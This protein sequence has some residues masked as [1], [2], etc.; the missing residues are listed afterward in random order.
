MVGRGFR[1]CENKKDCLVLD[2]GNNILRHGPVDAIYVR[3]QSDKSDKKM[4]QGKKCPDCNTVVALATRTCPDCGFQFPFETAR[5]EGNSSGNAPLTTKQNPIEEF[6][7]IDVRVSVH[8]KKGD[9]SAPT[10]MK[11]AYQYSYVD[12]P[13]YQWLCFNHEPGSFA[14]DMAKR[15]W[16][17]ASN[18]PLPGSSE[19]AVE[20]FNAG[21]CAMPI[22]IKAKLEERFYK[23][24]DIQFDE[25]P[26]WNEQRDSQWCDV[27]E[28][29]AANMSPNEDQINWDEVPF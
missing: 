20:M 7:I 9:P 4:K 29:A 28:K 25:K 15:W 26:E 10:T 14:H 17:S 13:I 27:F 23:I 19:E 1:I 8:S 16:R 21:F 11:L 3:P 5:H 22:K 12:S 6:E 2:F 24:V 18:A